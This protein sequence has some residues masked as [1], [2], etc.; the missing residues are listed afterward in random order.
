ME[1]LDVL[2]LN[3]CALNRSQISQFDHFN[4]SLT[5]IFFYDEVIF[6]VGGYND[7]GSVCTKLWNTQDDLGEVNTKQ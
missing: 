1:H 7:N 5:H 6:L 4:N 2:K 3:G